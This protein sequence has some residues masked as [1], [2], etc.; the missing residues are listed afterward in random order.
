MNQDTTQTIEQLLSNAYNDYSNLLETIL[1]IVVLVAIHF[2]INVI[3]RRQTED[4][5]AR[6]KWRKNLAYFL[7]FYRISADRPYLV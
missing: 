4:D 1:I 5:S 6:Y 2:V 7:K 3:V